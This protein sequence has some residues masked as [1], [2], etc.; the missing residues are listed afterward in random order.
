ME[1][2]VIIVS[3]NTR[4][5]L[6]KCLASIKN[7]EIIVVDNAS[8]DGS[9]EMVKKEFPAVKLIVNQKNLG[10]AKANNQALRQSQGDYFLLLNPDT[11]VKAGA[12]D[13]LLDFASSHPESGIIGPTL[14]NSNGSIQPSVYHFPSLWRA[15]KEYWL[16]QKDAYEKYA[17]TTSEAVVV[18]AVVGAVMLIPKKVVDK[19]GLLNEQFFMY[20]EDLDYCRRVNQAGLKVYYLPKAEVVHHHGQSTVKVGSLAYHYLSESSKIYNGLLKYYLLFL[21]IW[22]KQKWLQKQTSLFF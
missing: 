6:K 13:K 21:I 12:I 15:I 3:F 5:L 22:I 8:Q 14:L 17:I 20:F 2:S 11:Q 10:F 1:L 18:D 4:E 9:V 16:G 7:A 19:I